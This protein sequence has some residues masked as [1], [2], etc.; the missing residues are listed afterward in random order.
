MLRMAITFVILSLVAGIVAFGA[1]AGALPVI[2]EALLFVFLA[3][4][5][6]SLIF[7]RVAESDR[8]IVRGYVALS[9][10][11]R[12]GRAYLTFGQPVSRTSLKR[13]PHV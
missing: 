10:M 5:V 2:A 13:L 1:L 7:G 6:N 12:F 4:L 11:S 9:P 3:L 8:P